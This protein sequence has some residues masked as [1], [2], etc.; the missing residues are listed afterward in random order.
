MAGDFNAVRSLEER[1]GR[2]NDRREMDDFNAFIALAELVD[3][4]LSRR[5]FT[6]YKSGGE[7]MSRLDR[8]LLSP[9]M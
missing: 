2:M 4:R 9:E 1:K 8:V 3:L 6:W 5:K 7:A